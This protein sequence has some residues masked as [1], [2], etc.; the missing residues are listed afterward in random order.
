[1]FAAGEGRVD[2]YRIPS[3][4]VT[5]RDTIVVTA[6]AREVSPR[7]EDRHHLVARRSTD[8]GRTWGPITTIAAAD[9]P[10]P[11]CFPSDPVTLTPTRGPARG[12]VL[13]VFRPCRD[14]RAGLWL[15]RSRDDGRTWS[16]PAPLQVRPTA[17]VTADVLAG[18]RPGPGHGI[19]LGRAARGRLVLVADG[20][21]DDTA[22]APALVLLHS[23]DGGRTW[24]VGAATTTDR[25]GAVP[26]ESAVAARADGT[27]LVSSRGGAPGRLQVAATPDA[28]AFVPPGASPAPTSG[29][30]TPGVQ[31]SLLT[32][33]DGPV[34]LSSP[35]DATDRRGLRFFRAGP[36]TSWTPGPLVVPGPAAYSDL[37]M[38]DR[39]TVALVVETGARQPYERIELR[40]LPTS[41]VVGPADPLPDGFDAAGAVAGRLLVDGRRYTVV[42]FCFVS[43][44]ELAGGR[45]DVD[46]SGGLEA[47]EVR[48]VLDDVDGRPLELSGTVAVTPDVR[49]FTGRLA[50]SDGRDHDVDLV[51]ANALACRG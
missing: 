6:E 22:V 40:T 25:A 45:I 23:D 46:V 14:Q 36:G 3:I 44:V 51:I 19:E 37:A 17:T 27:L 34:V 32:L 16:E 15:T 11:G 43:P 12:D 8:R 7:D 28:T 26:D 2:T 31:G 50:G 9:R 10:G 35:S 13:V 48:V 18:L 20:N 39:S 21:M 4:G 47:A 33:P 41:I 5:P 42:R 29:L 30:V 24:D 38:A 1:M 49:L